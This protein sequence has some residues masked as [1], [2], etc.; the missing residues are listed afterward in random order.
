MRTNK[1]KAK[2]TIAIQLAIIALFTILACVVWWLFSKNIA[3]LQN[4]LIKTS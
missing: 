2:N 1:N 4:Q 3:E